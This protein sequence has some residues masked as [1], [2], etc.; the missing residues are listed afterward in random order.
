MKQFE[1][2]E[3]YDKYKKGDVINMNKDI[4]HTWIHPLLLRGVLKVIHSDKEIRKEV[5]QEI[6]D[7][8]DEENQLIIDQLTEKKMA[9]L[10]KFGKTYDA[11]DTKKSEIITEILEKAP[12]KEIIK[13]VSGD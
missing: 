6:D 1:F 11:I 2:I 10:Q 8:E 12:M 3:E 7:I 5:A 13:F 4:Y 9:E